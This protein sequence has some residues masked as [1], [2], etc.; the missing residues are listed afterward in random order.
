MFDLAQLRPEHFSHLPNSDFAVAGSDLCLRL[1]TVEVLHQPSPRGNAFSLVFALPDGFRG[2]QGTY[3]LQHPELGEL[4]LFLVP[5]APENGRNRL[6]A[7][8]N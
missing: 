5:I 3:A 4:R 8:F 2:A 1:T 7:I 6:E